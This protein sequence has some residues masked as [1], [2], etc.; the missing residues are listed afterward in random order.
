MKKLHKV[1]M[2]LFFCS[3]MAVSEASAAWV[4]PYVPPYSY[5]VQADARVSGLSVAYAAPY[6][7]YYAP[8]KKRAY[9]LPAPVVYAPAYAP[10]PIA[11]SPAPI[12]Y[13]AP[14]ASAPAPIYAPA[15]VAY[16]P[17]PVYY[18]PQVNLLY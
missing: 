7:Y 5:Y 8:V 1:L 9:R 15:P 13:Q 16:S 4:N 18:Y 11:Y 2:A 3:L 12:Y 6:A 10:A 17:Y 14:I